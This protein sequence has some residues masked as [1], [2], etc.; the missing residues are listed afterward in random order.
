MNWF[1]RNVYKK[2]HLHLDKICQEQRT[3]IEKYKE[4]ERDLNLLIGQYQAWVDVVRE[5][6]AKGDLVSVSNIMRLK[7]GFARKQEA[8]ENEIRLLRDEVRLLYDDIDEYKDWWAE[9]KEEMQKTGEQREQWEDAVRKAWEMGV[10]DARCLTRGVVSKG[11]LQGARPEVDE[12]EVEES[13]VEES[14]ELSNTPSEVSGSGYMSL[15]DELGGSDV[16]FDCD[17]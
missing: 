2:S 12:S 3:E 14:E 9:A 17:S 1:N 4:S 13:E 11:Q 15:A 7:E 10:E 6:V 8:Y 16:E 5:R